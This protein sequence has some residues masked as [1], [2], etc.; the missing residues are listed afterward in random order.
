MAVLMAGMKQ[1]STERNARKPVKRETT[2]VEVKLD[3]N[4]SHYWE[5]QLL[6]NARTP[7]PWTNSSKMKPDLLADSYQLAILNKT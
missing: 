3:K 6:D 2:E 4:L 1:L 7:W 5:K